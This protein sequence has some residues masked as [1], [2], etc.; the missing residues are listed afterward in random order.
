MIINCIYAPG[1]VHIYMLSD[2][3]LLEH[4]FEEPFSAVYEQ[5]LVQKY[6]AEKTQA[7]I[8]NGFLEYY[9]IPCGRGQERC[10]CRLSEKGRLCAR[11]LLPDIPA[12]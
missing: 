12:N 7:A 5:D 11:G 9:R 4:Y 10:V 2:L 6:G 1:R 3:Y 8:S